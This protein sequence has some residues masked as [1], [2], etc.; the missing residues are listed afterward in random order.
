MEITIRCKYHKEVKLH[1]DML[2]TLWTVTPCYKCHEDSRQQ[3]INFFVNDLG[4][5]AKRLLS[6][7]QER[8]I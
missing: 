5:M 6:E 8:G 7:R 1:M 2:G 3:G 4:K